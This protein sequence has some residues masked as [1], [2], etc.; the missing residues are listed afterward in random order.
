[1][2]KKWYD[3]T[4]DLMW[5][6]P[7]IDIDE[8]RNSIVRYRYVHGGF[9]GTETKFAFFYPEKKAYKQRFFHFMSP[10]QGSENAEL[11]ANGEYSKIAFAITHDSY[12]VETNM[13]VAIP[14]APIVDPTI[15]YRSSAA[16]AEYSRKIASEMYGEHRAWGYMYGGSGGAFKTF[17]CMEN[18]RV[19]DGAVPM[20]S[21]SPMSIPNCFT[22]RAHARRVLRRKLSQIANAV[23]PGGATERIFSF[24]SD[25]V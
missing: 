11:E 21:G 17:S 13:G 3:P 24:S 2:E 10:V 7:Y 6:K 19:W 4:N 16:A 5:S 25:S 15:I 20:V 18:T 8:W 23:Q 12:Y 14:F 22:I 9:E 1:M